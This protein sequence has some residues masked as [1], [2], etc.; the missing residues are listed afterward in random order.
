MCLWVQHSRIQGRLLYTQ[1]KQESSSL[2][3]SLTTPVREDAEA[4]ED[5]R[6]TYTLSPEATYLR[7]GNSKV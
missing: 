3:V 7:L 6:G 1:C 5:L 2:P 4:F